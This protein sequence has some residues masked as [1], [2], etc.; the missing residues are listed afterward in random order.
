MSLVLKDILTGTQAGAGFVSTRKYSTQETLAP[1][2]NVCL[3]RML[4]VYGCVF[5]SI[6][7]LLVHLRMRM[8]LNS[9]SITGVPF[10]LIVILRTTFVLRTT[11]MRSCCN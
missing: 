7:L 1:V 9:R 3:S 5:C 10:N 2:M 6:P 11:C 4:R 8:S